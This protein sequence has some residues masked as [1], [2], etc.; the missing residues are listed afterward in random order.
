[1]T[2]GMNFL[3]FMT[4]SYV[5][6]PL[7]KIFV[8]SI[9]IK[10]LCAPIFHTLHCQMRSTSNQSEARTSW[11]GQSENGQMCCGSFTTG[12]Q[13]LVTV[14]KGSPFVRTRSQV[15]TN[16]QYSNNWGR[17]EGLLFGEGAPLDK[18]WFWLALVSC[19]HERLTL[20]GFLNIYIVLIYRAIGQ[21]KHP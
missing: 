16:I 5:L 7:T 20:K 11:V 15:V 4:S 14:Y 18:C 13:F 6:W 19:S 21:V 8:I 9:S 3:K 1:M 12:I 10:S 2:K 17:R